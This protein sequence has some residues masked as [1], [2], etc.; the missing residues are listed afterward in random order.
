[1]TPPTSSA[2]PEAPPEVPQEPVIPPQAPES[3]PGAQPDSKINVHDD[4]LSFIG[5]P[6]A[7]PAVERRLAFLPR[8]SDQTPPLQAL[9]RKPAFLTRAEEQGKVLPLPIRDGARPVSAPST[10]GIP[11]NLPRPPAGPGQ[12]P[13]L[14]LER[15][16]LPAKTEP[17]SLTA[18]PSPEDRPPAPPRPD[19][20]KPEPA[21][22]PPLREQIV[23]SA[24]PPLE[25]LVG[26]QSND[27]KLA[28]IHDAVADQGIRLPS[29]A[30]SDQAAP[31]SA[32]VG[33]AQAEFGELSVQEKRLAE[34]N[35]TYPTQLRPAIEALIDVLPDNIEIGQWIDTTE[36]GADVL[37]F[38][39]VGP[40]GQLQS[41]LEGKAALDAE[42][43]RQMAITKL[44][45]EQRKIILERW[46]ELN[47]QTQAYL[48][49]STE[50]HPAPAQSTALIQSGE[51][52]EVRIED[53]AKA[54]SSGSAAAGAETPAS[55]EQIVSSEQ[56][57]SDLTPEQQV[58]FQQKVND[59][60]Q[61][62]PGLTIAEWP[63]FTEVNGTRSAHFSLTAKG[64]EVTQDQFSALATDAASKPAY[65]A[66]I[67]FLSDKHKSQATTVSKP[68]ILSTIR[69]WF[70]RKK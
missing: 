60:A 59:L 32:V 48:K 11:L 55:G 68:G 10:L 6:Q 27:D 37:P 9:D 31:P 50:Q 29:V 40:D 54:P 24:V 30:A 4:F 47:A 12:R 70:T 18:P 15:P 64:V 23:Q 58:E 41:L 3:A 39:L 66:F 63:T 1:M 7:T 44:T 42:L 19:P 51:R 49:Q 36:P 5:K 21:P 14:K 67:K 8:R 61:Y 34:S 56:P 38:H 57:K 16:E 2:T 45:S 28:A 26:T 46:T 43:E 62:L 53:M 33:R 35:A 52:R 65:D 17:A 69:G 25:N 22:T 20:A 13:A